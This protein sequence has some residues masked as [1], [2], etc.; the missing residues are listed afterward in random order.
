ML[1]LIETQS[2]CL[3][4]CSKDIETIKLCEYVFGDVK[5]VYFVN[6]NILNRFPCKLFSPKKLLTIIL[7]KK[8]SK[9]SC[10]DIL[11]LLEMTDTERID[12][13]WRYL[14]NDKWIYS[15]A[16]GIALGKKNF[17]MP[18]MPTIDYQEYRNSLIINAMKKVNGKVLFPL[19][20]MKE[21]RFIDK[22]DIVI[23]HFNINM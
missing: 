5:N 12:R 9:M 6:N 15:V 11:N 1:D 20:E 10:E 14:G 7:R 2:A 8:Y 4:F 16:L 19:A 13:Q 22:Q 3:I 17:C 23:K 21:F 18:W